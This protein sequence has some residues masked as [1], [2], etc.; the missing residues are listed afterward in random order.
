MGVKAGRIVGETEEGDEVGLIVGKLVGY[1]GVSDGVTVG[2]VGSMVGVIVL[3]VH[4]P[5]VDVPLDTRVP[6]VAL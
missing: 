3:I 6:V 1:V 5:Q 2:E 4:V